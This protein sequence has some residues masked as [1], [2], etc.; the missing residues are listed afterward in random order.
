MWATQSSEAGKCLVP[1][2]SVNTGLG[3]G[4]GTESAIWP[5]LSPR[6]FLALPAVAAAIVAP[7]TLGPKSPGNLSCGQSRED[8]CSEPVEGGG[9]WW[10][11]GNGSG[12][13]VADG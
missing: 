5:S 7:G 11:L 9:S 12:P 13:R 8:W 6:H 2:C 3:P 1:S 4:S 10:H